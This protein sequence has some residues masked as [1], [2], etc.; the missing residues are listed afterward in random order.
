MF[1]VSDMFVDKHAGGAEL[2]SEAIIQ[3]SYCDVKKI[4]STAVTIELLEENKDEYWIF[5]NF[6][7][8]QQSALIYAATHLKYSILE[9][10]YKYCKYRSPEKHVFFE[11]ECDCHVQHCGKVISVF[12]AKAKS[13]WFMSE[14]Q[15]EYY[16]NIFPF[17]KNQNSFVLSS[18]FDTDTLD[19]I[20]G[21][22]TNKN[23]KWLI[24]HTGSWIKGTQK[25]IDYAQKH[26]LEYFLAENL[27]Y[28]NMLEALASSKGLIFLPL[29]KDT[30]PRLVI[31]AK[32]LDCELVINEKVQHATEEWFDSKESA[33]EYLE[34]RPQFFW[35]E[36][37]KEE[38]KCAG[39]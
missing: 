31:E 36:I 22:E 19:F 25:G 24:V 39:S 4:E 29:G 30:C 33:Y 13:L 8:V 16:E 3:A 28:K 35:N 32:L 27:S 10:D 12:F 14:K 37:R 34:R 5:G 21:L 6:S 17:L 9:Y 26:D 23:N 20:G 15:K 2:T 11:K 38:L 7:M 1:F 18:V